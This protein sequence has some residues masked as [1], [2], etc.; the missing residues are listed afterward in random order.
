MPEEIVSYITTYG[1]VAIFVLIFLQEIGMPNPIP[2]ELL[3]LFTGYL[4]FKGLLYLP[5]VIITAAAADFIG[6][7]ILYTV[8]YTSGTFLLQKKPRWIPISEIKITRFREKIN[9][10]GWLNI[11][12]FRLMSVTRGYASIITGLLHMKPAKYLPIVIMSAFTW[13]MLYAI[14]GFILG[15]SWNIIITNI[16]H[17]KFVMS[18]ILLLIICF[19]IL[20][21]FRKKQITQKNKANI[22]PV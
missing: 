17:F 7:N 14:L 11:F 5:F 2:V 9:S 4:S 3:V 21:W 15:P 12:L 22:N 19:Y 16:D 18:G 8:F 10:G 1:Y 6:A 13:T 20:R